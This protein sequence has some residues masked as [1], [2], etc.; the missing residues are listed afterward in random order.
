[1][2]TTLSILFVA[3]FLALFLTLTG[4][5]V[6]QGTPDWITPSRETVCD[7][8]SGTAF[9]LCNAYCE[10][11]DCHLA[12]PQASQTAC[13][14]VS[15][16]FTQI[17]GRSLP[18]EA[19]C[20]CMNIPEFADYV[21]GGASVNACLLNSSITQLEGDLSGFVSSFAAAGDL[22]GSFCGFIGETLEGAG[23]YHL[24]STTPEE[25]VTCQLLLE[26]AAAAQ[27]VTCG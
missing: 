19:T 18:C 7:D 13:D 4:S 21:N 16:K 22:S 26:D 3:M 6:A 27:S 9:G 24:L 12:E 14:K 8:E 25:A 23:L 10:A 11:M 5:A 20:P 15:N 2:R 1:M 17:T